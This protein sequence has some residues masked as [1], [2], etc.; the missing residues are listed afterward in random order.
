VNK[1]CFFTAI[2]NSKE[3]GLFINYTLPSLLS[4][5]NIPSI[6]NKN[7]TEYLIWT[8]DDYV[9]TL[10]KSNGIAQLCNYLN[11]NIK[12][13]SRYF[14]MG[15]ESLVTSALY[16]GMLENSQ[17]ENFGVFSIQ[18]DVIWA[19]GTIL[20]I[21]KKANEGIR[22][23]LAGSILTRSKHVLDTLKTSDNH[24]GEILSVPPRKLVQ[25]LLD[26]EHPIT[27]SQIID[28]RN[29][30][31][32]PNSIYWPLG[33]QG[34]LMRTTELHPLY[35]HPK[36]YVTNFKKSFAD[37]FLKMAVPEEEDYYIANN[38][39][40]IFLVRTDFGES[41]KGIPDRINIANET[42]FGL[43]LNN[44]CTARDRDNLKHHIW[45]HKG[46][47]I[48]D[49]RSSINHSNIFIQKSISFSKA[50]EKQTTT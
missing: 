17:K 45:L 29:F 14:F 41:S 34:Y 28:N 39:D 40:E 19:D 49:W 30:S 16:R 22:V 24:A 5:N 46:I 33:D 27:S 12:G 9:D 20:K 10:S 11:V 3:L 50:F 44:Y 18:P 21:D 47:N 1:K 31:T 4:K 48:A 35:V 13:V 25:I 43:W 7:N 6:S 42:F 2:A 37:D 8:S 36:N 38:S 15:K 26:D 23:I 32:W